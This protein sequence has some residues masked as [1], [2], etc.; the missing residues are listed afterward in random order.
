MA[1]DLEDPPVGA[2][3]YGWKSHYLAML[4]AAGYRVPRGIALA[5]DEQITTAALSR[6]TVD[7]RVPP[8]AVR[9]SALA[10]DSVAQSYAGSFTTRLDVTADLASGD[11]NPAASPA[12][13][14]AAV[15]DVRRSGP[16]GGMGVVVQHMVAASISGVAFSIDPATYS[17]STAAV[18]WTSGGGE[19]LV[20]GATSGHDVLIEKSSG[21][22]L[23]GHWPHGPGYLSELLD[24]LSDLA[25]RLNG[26]V[27]VEWCIEQDTGDLFLLQVR[28]VVL[29][30][31]QILDLMA[32]G[33]F[34]RLPAVVANHPKMHLRREA[35]RAGIP[36]TPARLT[37]AT[38]R[39]IP[40]ITSVDRSASAAGSSVVLLHPF[41]VDN[42]VVREFANVDKSDVE[43][44]LR[45]CR[46]YS[47]R[48]YPSFDGIVATEQWVLA[49]G[50]ANSAVTVV[51]EQEIWDAQLTGIVRRLDDGYLVEVALGHFVPKG[52]VRTS[53]YLV[54]DKL[55]ITSRHETTQGTAYHFRNGHV[56][57]EESPEWNP[58]LDAPTVARLLRTLMPLLESDPHLALEFGVTRP[59]PEGVVYLIDAAESDHPDVHLRTDTFQ[60]GV[61]SHG[62]AA[63]VVV[64][65]RSGTDQVDFNA[66]LYQS[67]E[68][69]RPDRPTIFIAARASVNLLPLLYACPPGSA[70]VFETASLLAHVAVVM[71]ERGVPGAVLGVEELA[72]LAAAT[73]A[74][75]DTRRT[76]MWRVDPSS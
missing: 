46:R 74:V 4:N 69:E 71:R 38:A 10:E 55:E 37:I 29:P 24:A 42:R 25:G 19:A 53:T 54:D 28:P 64:D 70:F 40:A 76:P 26:P 48:Q 63:G 52:Y 13:V 65:L 49:V 17:L 59:G 18:S 68:G 51:L 22:P 58:R 5:V 31:A 41:T 73:T 27:D 16:L 72:G 33:S 15:D 47:I 60:P 2:D 1:H 6:L 44:W 11:S 32:P 21:T 12:I 62:R 7:G 8:L 39:D 20:S 61:V 43:F 34:E 3:R 35:A 9:S 23:R 57:R 56:V 67:V 45:G 50:L 66:H 75:L 36:M 14:A 30:A